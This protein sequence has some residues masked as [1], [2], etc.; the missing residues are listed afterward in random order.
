MLHPLLAWDVL[1]LIESLI[2]IAWSVARQSRAF[3]FSGAF[4]LFVAITL[5]NLDYFKDRLG[6]PVVLLITGVA[7]IAIGLGVDRLRRRLG[8]RT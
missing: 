3:L 8:P 7:F 5:I 6:L 4:W 2:F 1:L